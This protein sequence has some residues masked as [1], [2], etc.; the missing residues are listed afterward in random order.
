MS[1][2]AN[3]ARLAEILRQANDAAIAADPGER[4]DRGTCNLDSA[5]FRLPPAFR[6]DVVVEAGRVAGVT[7]MAC[8]QYGR[9]AFFPLFAIH[10]QAERRT[11]MM[12]AA[13]ESLF[14]SGFPGLTACM[15]YAID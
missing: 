11:K 12:E 15:H 14:N 10:G 13:H 6:S 5:Y 4:A 3:I 1:K 8:S 7:V 9:R 2:E